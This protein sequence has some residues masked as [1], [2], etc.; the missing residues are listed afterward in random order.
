MESQQTNQHFEI[1]VRLAQVDQEPLCACATSTL[2]FKLSLLFVTY[3]DV[4]E[5]SGEGVSLLGGSPGGSIFPV[6]MRQF[7][8]NRCM[9]CSSVVSNSKVLEPV[10]LSGSFCSSFSSAFALTEFWKHQIR[11]IKYQSKCNANRCKE[12]ILKRCNA[13]LNLMTLDEILKCDQ[14]NESYWAVLSCG[15]VYSAVQGSTNFWVCGWNPKVWPFK[16]KLRSNTVLK[17][18]LLR[19]ARW[20]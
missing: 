14:S 11:R 2:L 7:R 12:S 19:L 20:F 13:A 18:C 1:L 8:S 10:L 6:Q 16:W 5:T 4:V 9:R 17:C 15:T 3:I